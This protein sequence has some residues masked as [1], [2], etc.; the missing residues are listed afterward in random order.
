MGILVSERSGLE[1][2]RRPSENES[3]KDTVLT[4]LLLFEVV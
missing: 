4:L 3:E 1:K 2:M